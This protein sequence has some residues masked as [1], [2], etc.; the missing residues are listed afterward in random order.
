MGRLILVVILMAIS[1]VVYLVKAGAR[2]VTGGK[3]VNFQEES[4][5]VMEKTAK[6]VEWMNEQWEQAKSQAKS[7]ESSRSLKTLKFDGKPAND[8]I[9]NIRGNPGEYNETEAEAIYVEQALR[10]IQSGQ[11][12]EAKQ[13]AYQVLDKDSREYILDKAGN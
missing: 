13:L 6:G 11:P 8:I 1:G 5:K 3:E 9:A 2:K 7:E 12:E 10:K 4:Q